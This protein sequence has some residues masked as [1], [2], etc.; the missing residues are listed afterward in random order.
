[1]RCRD[2]GQLGGTPSREPG[3]HRT[4]LTATAIRGALRRPG[5]AHLGQRPIPA[6]RVYGPKQQWEPGRC[7]DTGFSRITRTR[8]TLFERLDPLADRRRRRHAGCSAAASKLPASSPPRRRRRAA[9]HRG[10]ARRRCYSGLCAGF[11]ERDRVAAS[12][13][14]WQWRGPAASRS[15]TSV[16]APGRSSVLVNQA[17][18]RQFI[19][20]APGD[21]AVGSPR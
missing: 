2:P 17:S 1:M 5:T 15:R 7:C 10:G 18:N 3:V 11:A 19:A 9:V 8:P 16:W 20:D 12:R 13:S 4:A 14:P 21:S 6:Q